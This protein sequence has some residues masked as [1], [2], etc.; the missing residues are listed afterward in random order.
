VSTN[1]LPLAPWEDKPVDCPNDDNIPCGLT[2]LGRHASVGHV[3]N[4]RI[5]NALTQLSIKNCG[6]MLRI[7]GWLFNEPDVIVFYGPRMG[8]LRRSILLNIIRN[9]E[10]FVYLG[11]FPPLAP[12]TRPKSDKLE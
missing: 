5:T 6:P 7:L 8:A 4:I 10:L 3:H 11:F 9:V 2:I 12:Y 1:S